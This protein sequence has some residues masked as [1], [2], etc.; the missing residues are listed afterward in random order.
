MLEVKNTCPNKIKIFKIYKKIFILKLFLKE[1][2]SK[3][4]KRAANLLGFKL[5]NFIRTIFES[6]YSVCLKE[7]DWKLINLLIFEDIK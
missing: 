4:I 3:Q 2:R 1:G 6:F 5:T 7:G